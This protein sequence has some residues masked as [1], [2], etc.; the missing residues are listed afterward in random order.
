MYILVQHLAGVFSGNL[1][2]VVSMDNG[3]A[4][5]NHFTVS[6]VNVVA[7]KVGVNYLILVVMLKFL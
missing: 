3:D 4:N 6:S 1:D 2:A 7:S 5:N